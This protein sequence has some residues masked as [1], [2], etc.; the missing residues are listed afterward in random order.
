MKIV[1][2]IENQVMAVVYENSE[3]DYLVR[4][5]GGI[6]DAMWVKDFMEKN[7]YQD[8]YGHYEY[9][10]GEYYELGFNKKN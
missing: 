6:R 9:E 4:I 8:V 3:Y 2:K 5:F 7:N 1:E 10:D